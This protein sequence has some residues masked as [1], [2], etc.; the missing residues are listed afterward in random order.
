MNFIDSSFFL[1][2]SGSR[3]RKLM[4]SPE[5]NGKKK[6]RGVSRND[7]AKRCVLFYSDG[8]DFVYTSSTRK[9]WKIILIF[10]IFFIYGTVFFF[11]FQRRSTK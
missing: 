3:K 4:T 2:S 11:F 6:K 1:Q 8:P 7:D 5:P 10:V 9:V